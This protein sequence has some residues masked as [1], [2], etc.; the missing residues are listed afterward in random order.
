MQFAF[1]IPNDNCSQLYDGKQKHHQDRFQP[2]DQTEMLP[3][4]TVQTFSLETV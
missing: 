1:C 4:S 3:R 2:R